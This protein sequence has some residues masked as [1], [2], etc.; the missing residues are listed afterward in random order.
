MRKILVIILYSAAFFSCKKDAKLPSDTKQTEGFLHYDNFP[1]GFGLYYRIDFTQE[2]IL[3]PNTF[4]SDSAQYQFYKGYV[5]VHSRLYYLDPGY[6][7]CV[8]G[9]A[10]VCG[11]RLVEPIKLEKE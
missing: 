3:F 1:D 2:L 9:F 8:F 6:Y 7:G 4:S 5:N 11:F 10:R